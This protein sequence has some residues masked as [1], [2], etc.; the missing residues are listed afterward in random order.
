MT[1][2]TRL[3]D[4]RRHFENAID[5]IKAKPFAWYD[6]DC[7]PGLAGRLVEAQTGVNL[8][9]FAVG[10]YH[11][12]ASAARLL[13]ELG[14]ETLGALVASILPSIHPSEARVGD[15]A[16]LDVGGPIG[17]A[18]GVV[19]GERIFVLTEAGIGTVDLLDA[20]M[21]FKVG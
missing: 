9:G 10:R 15:I 16:A 19:N 5:D 2:L 21:A 7:G 20:A 18:L 13:R 4:W 1:A 11:D 14:F 8:S 3:P 12:A 6:H 17:H